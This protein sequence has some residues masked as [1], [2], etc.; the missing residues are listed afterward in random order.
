MTAVF[1]GADASARL[2]V[3]NVN[4]HGISARAAFG[5]EPLA[6]IQDNKTA[7]EKDNLVARNTTVTTT[8]NHG[9]KMPVGDVLV[10]NRPSG[11]LWARSSNSDNGR[12]VVAR[13]ATNS[14]TPLRMPRAHEF[15]QLDDGFVLPEE[16]LFKDSRL[17]A[18]I[19]SSSNMRKTSASANQY[20]YSDFFAGVRTPGAAP[21][22]AS[23]AVTARS[24]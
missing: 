10:P 21:M 18:M 17:D 20:D 15:A 16:S 1:C 14:D 11:D 8:T 2:P 6:K 22:R 4:G 7:P 19:A 9:L 5:L 3:M 24:S 13:A 12:N 23:Q